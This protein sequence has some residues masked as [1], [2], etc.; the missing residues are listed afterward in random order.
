MFTQEL[1]HTGSMHSHVLIYMHI[2]YSICG[3]NGTIRPGDRILKVNGMNLEHV[4]H[5]EAVALLK[6]AEQN[7]T[8]ELEYDVTIHG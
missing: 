8:L 1:Q 4:T 5:A 2:I 6:T 3:R 7:I